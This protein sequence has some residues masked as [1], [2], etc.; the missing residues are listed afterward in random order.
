LHRS[1]QSPVTR[2]RLRFSLNISQEQRLSPVYSRRITAAK[3]PELTS[4]SQRVADQL[5]FSPQKSWRD[6]AW[7]LVCHLC[8]G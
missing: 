3:G 5:G 1:L 8:A 7:M 4:F 6:E 2:S